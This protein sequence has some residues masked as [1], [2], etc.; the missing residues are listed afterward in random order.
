MRRYIVAKLAEAGLAI[1]H[2]TRLGVCSV[3]VV[4]GAI[5]VLIE[6]SRPKAIKLILG[7]LGEVDS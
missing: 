7:H 4:G 3:E 6:V 5:G 1:S 2:N